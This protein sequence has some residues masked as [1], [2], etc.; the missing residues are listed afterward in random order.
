MTGRLNSFLKS[1]LI[2]AAITFVLIV[3][4]SLPHFAMNMS[5][6]MDGNM[7]MNNCYMPGMTLICSMTPIQHISEWQR[8][9]TTTIQQMPTTVLLLLLALTIGLSQFLIRLLTPK[10]KEG[11]IQNYRYRER[12]FDPLRLAFARGIIHPKVF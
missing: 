5:A 10:P 1:V 4:L 7:A 2:A 8:M 9:F 12:V 3:G 6:D 11:P